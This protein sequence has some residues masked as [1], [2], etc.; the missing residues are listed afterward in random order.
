V[1][2]NNTKVVVSF[3]N[4]ITE[5]NGQPSIS[6]GDVRALRILQEISKKGNHR[7]IVFTSTIGVKLINNYARKN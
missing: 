5:N 4:G 6:G 2:E 3:I 7:V 1:K